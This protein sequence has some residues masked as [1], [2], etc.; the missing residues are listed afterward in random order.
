MVIP[1]YGQV[2]F[3]D[4]HGVLC[5]AQFWASARN[6]PA[7]NRGQHFEAAVQAL[8]ASSVV[9]DWM[10]GRVSTREVISAHLVQSDDARLIDFL[11]R[12]VVAEC[13]RSSLRARL[14]KTLRLLRSRFH[15]VL[16]TDNMDCFIPALRRRSD[17][18]SIFD[19]YLASTDLGVLKA[20]DPERFFLPWLRHHD[21]PVTKAVLLDDRRKNCER[22]TAIG[23]RAIVFDDSPAAWSQLAALTG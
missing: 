11:E 22:F 10:R 17:L 2:L 7:L 1:V 18:L 4:W 12:Q 23:G 6:H 9:E 20:E 15:L 13:E 8:F 16:A 21:I 14:V 19:D 3:V 5:E